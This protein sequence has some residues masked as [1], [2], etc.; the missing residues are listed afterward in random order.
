ML[1]LLELRAVDRRGY[2]L[3][4]VE[5]K[6][7]EKTALYEQEDCENAILRLCKLTV[8]AKTK[9]NEDETDIAMSANKIRAQGH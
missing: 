5:D 6:V 4:G 1:E 9:F 3:E 2:M 7:I 8:Q